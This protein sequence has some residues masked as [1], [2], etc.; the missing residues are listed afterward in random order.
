MQMLHI[1]YELIAIW[2]WVSHS[3]YNSICVVPSNFCMRASADFWVHIDQVWLHPC[4]NI[5]R[6]WQPFQR[7]KY[8]IY[9]MNWLPSEYGWVIPCATR[10]LLCHLTISCEPLQILKCKHIELICI[11]VARKFW[12]DNHSSYTGAPNN[13]QTNCHPNIGALDGAE[14]AFFGAIPFLI[15][16]MEF[17]RAGLHLYGVEFSAANPI[18][19]MQM[20]PSPELIAIQIWV[21]H[22]IYLQLDLWYSRLAIVHA[23]LCIFW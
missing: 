12:R 6:E 11:R 17:D 5:F 4:G 10:F 15:G 9:H 20:L 14:H 2:L 3:V 22:F 21:H 18:P 1:S 13:T 23:D 16:G 8:S 19:M 7:Y